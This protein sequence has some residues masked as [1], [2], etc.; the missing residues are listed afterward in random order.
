V[1]L[2]GFEKA[3]PNQLSGGMKQRVAIARSL[4][5]GPTLLLLDEP[6]GALD[7]ITRQRMNLELL[8]IWGETG[9]T[10]VLITHSLQEAVFL[11]DRI[12]VMSARPGR[13]AEEIAVDLPRPR[14]PEMMREQ[15]FYDTL[16]AVGKVLFDSVE[17]ETLA[18][19]EL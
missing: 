15:R 14:T 8:R 16:T 7:E 19:A 3:R 4:V 10:A 5:L 18:T 2:S 11:S 9:T 17:A 12:L 13:I 6:F 1:G